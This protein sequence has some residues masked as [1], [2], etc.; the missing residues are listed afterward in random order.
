MRNSK[1]CYNKT[2]ELSFFVIVIEIDNNFK[3]R[4]SRNHFEYRFSKNNCAESCMNYAKFTQ[5]Y[6]IAFDLD[7]EKKILK[8]CSFFF[9]LLSHVSNFDDCIIINFIT[10]KSCS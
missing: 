2:K 1:N 4:F 10:L 6:V 7:D 5:N 8:N 9:L 3:S